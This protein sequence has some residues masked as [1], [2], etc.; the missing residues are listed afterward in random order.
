MNALID[1]LS[2]SSFHSRRVILVSSY[3]FKVENCIQLNI[4]VN[5][6]VQQQIWERSLKDQSQEVS[7]GI[8]LSAPV[9]RMEIIGSF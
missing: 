8:G 4:S 7:L 3:L 9:Y 5:W 6:D 1:H 2:S